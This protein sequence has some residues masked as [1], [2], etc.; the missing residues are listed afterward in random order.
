MI[1]GE[2][3]VNDKNELSA[4]IIFHREAGGTVF[5]LNEGR[6]LCGPITLCLDQAAGNYLYLYNTSK[7]TYQQI[8]YTNM[9]ELKLTTGGKYLLT[10]KRLSRFTINK[11]VYAGGMLCCIVIG[12]VYVRMKKKYWFW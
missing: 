10:E 3:I 9:T 2:D 12:A 4:Q 8:E 6:E 11:M 7:D 5:E 1:H